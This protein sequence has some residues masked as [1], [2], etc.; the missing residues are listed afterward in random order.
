MGTKRSS[1][2]SVEPS[3][4]EP[5][6]F[7]VEYGSSLIEIEWGLGF[8][9]TWNC[10]VEALKDTSVQAENLKLNHPRAQATKVR[11]EPPSLSTPT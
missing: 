6:L 7:A 3:R 11:L 9:W 10:I 4:A 2:V 5:S 8:P 1:R